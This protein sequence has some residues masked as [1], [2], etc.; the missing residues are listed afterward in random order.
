MNGNSIG[1]ALVLTCFGESHGRVIGAVL[2]GCPAGLPISREDIQAEM[3]KRRPGA[4][5]ITSR[6]VEEDVVEILSG[7]YRGYTTGAPICMIIKNRDVDSKPYEEIKYKP[8]PGH[9]DYTAYIRYGGFNDYRGGGRF[10]GR[11]TAAYVMAGA[12]AKKMLRTINV[13]VLAHTVQIG[14]VKLRREVS[15]D[16]IRRNVYNNE[17]RCADPEVA[18]EMK[19]EVL[20]ALREGDS[21]GGVVEGIALNVPAG[22]GDPIF[23]SLDSD[24]AKM[25]FNIPAV[26]AVEFGAGFNAASMKGSENNDPYRIINGK[27][28]AEKNDAGGILGGI[29]TGMPIIVRAAFKPTPSISKRQRTVDLNSMEN[30]NIEL[31]GRHD[32]CIVPRAV[33][34]VEACIA[35]VIADHSL[36][37]G[38]IS[39]ILK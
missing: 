20:E 17:V 38:I 36:R 23:D 12:V 19:S 37:A 4:S 25:L 26:K 5:P 39:R 3:D 13:E 33:P 27:V 35:L 8:R 11:I 18:E 29:S 21:V 6:R 30:V 15:Y 32:P 34:V 2:D 24:I 10:S 1:K 9:A 28:V 14:R 16:E 7:V 22:L 31:K